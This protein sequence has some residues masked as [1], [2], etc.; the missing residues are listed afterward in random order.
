MV[1]QT[2]LTRNALPEPRP[3]GNRPSQCRTGGAGD[4][5]RH[6]AER[7]GTVQI[8]GRH[9]F[10]DVGLLRGLVEGETHP[11]HEGQQQQGRRIDP[12][13]QGDGAERGRGHEQNGLRDEDDLSSVDDVGQRPA[14]QSEEQCRR[15]ARRLHQGDHQRRWRDRRHQ[16]CGHGRLH[17]VAQGRADGAEIEVAETQVPERRRFLQFGQER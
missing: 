8:P 16:P 11:D 4:I 12:T 1:K 9:Q 7:D 14:D 5:E 3:G 2:A 10:I 13:G 15:G 6:G 17:G